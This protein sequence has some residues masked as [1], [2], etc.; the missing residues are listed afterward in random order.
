MLNVPNIYIRP[1][2]Q[3]ELADSKKSQFTNKDGDHLS[4]LNTFTSFKQ[5][6]MDS[7]WCWS[8]YLNFRALKQ[9]DSIREQLVRIMG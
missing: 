8:N 3:T 1:R 2:N 5:N 7:D 9:A 6:G 4:L